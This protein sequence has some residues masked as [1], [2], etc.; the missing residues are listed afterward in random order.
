[1]F[2]SSLQLAKLIKLRSIQHLTIESFYLLT[3]IHF[4]TKANSKIPKAN[5]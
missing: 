2:A 1:M 4:V 5:F 3:Q